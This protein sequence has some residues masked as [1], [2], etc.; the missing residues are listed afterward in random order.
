MSPCGPW[1]PAGGAP[2]AQVAVRS[3]WSPPCR[4]GAR[5][6]VS[7]RL[8]GRGSIPAP[9]PRRALPAVLPAALWAPC[10]LSRPAPPAVPSRPKDTTWGAEAEPWPG[11]ARGLGVAHPGFRGASAGWRDLRAAVTG[12]T[13]CFQVFKMRS[14]GRRRLRASGRLARSCTRRPGPATRTAGSSAPE[15]AA[16]CVGG[17]PASF[18]HLPFRPAPPLG[19][20]GSPTGILPAC[21]RGASPPGRDDGPRC[22]SRQGKPEPGLPVTP[23]SWTRP[24]R[25]STGWRRRALLRGVPEVRSTLSCTPSAERGPL[26]SGHQRRAAGDGAQPRQEAARRPIQRAA[27]C[28]EVALGRP[29]TGVTAPPASG[30]GQPEGARP[31][32]IPLVY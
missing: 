20:G 32:A 18:Q 13:P 1:A 27:K 23:G 7:L 10:S 12:G 25:A 16:A 31:Q 11:A 24:R 21:A 6:W 5:V 19:K 26:G 8:A 30:V 17:L 9:T 29:A 22:R 4:V 14:S 15:H 28:A 3:A 2:A